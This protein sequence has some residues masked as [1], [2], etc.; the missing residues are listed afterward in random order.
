MTKICSCKKSASKSF[1]KICENIQFSTIFDFPATKTTSSD[2][3]KKIE[4][5]F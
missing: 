3:G 2:G 4:Q 1:V 5:K